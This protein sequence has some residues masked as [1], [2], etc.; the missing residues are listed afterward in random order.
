MAK[1]A[2]TVATFLAH[3]RD[4]VREP[5]F[6]EFV[7]EHVAL[8]GKATDP[9]P[10][11]DRYYLEDLLRNKKYKFDSK[12]LS[13]Y[14]EVGAVTKGLLDV[15]SQMYGLEYKEVPA[16]AWHADVSAYEVYSDGKLIGKFYLDLYPRADKYKHAAMFP[17]RSAKRL[18][19]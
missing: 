5:A 7:K 10:L 9:I 13:S 2:A 16:E 18:A 17:I 6:A 14:F 19:D 15:T 1:S 4:A 3:V 11:S 12:E 8:G